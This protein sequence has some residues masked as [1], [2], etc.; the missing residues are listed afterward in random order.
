MVSLPRLVRSAW[1]RAK[2]NLHYANEEEYMFAVAD[3][4][5]EEYKAITDA[6]LIMQVDEPEFATTWS[7]LS[8]LDR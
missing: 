3:C 1:V 4:M 2:R 5:R 8:G 7:V 6:G